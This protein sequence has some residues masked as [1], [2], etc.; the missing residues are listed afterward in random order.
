[1]SNLAFFVMEGSSTSTLQTDNDSLRE[2]LK[3]LRVKLCEQ[4]EKCTELMQKVNPTHIQPIEKP[5][6]K[7]KISINTTFSL[8]K[9]EGQVRRVKAYFG[10]LIRKSKI[11]PNTTYRTLETVLAENWVEAAKSRYEET[12]GFQEW[13]FREA[14]KQKLQDRS[15]YYKRKNKLK[16]KRVEKSVVSTMTVSSDES[17]IEV[18]AV[19]S[20]EILKQTSKQRKGKEPAAT[21]VPSDESEI[22]ILKQTSKQR[23][24]KEPAVP[25]DESEIEILKQTSKKRKGKEPAF[26]DPPSRRTRNKMK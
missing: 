9:K 11:P 1:M 5:L 14:L 22:E 7:S 25:I 2:E 3:E 4:Q 13:V 23:K 26:S 18:M 6:G 16:A 17:E 8:N 12:F 21:T 19:P 20:N 10:D 24:G 15:S